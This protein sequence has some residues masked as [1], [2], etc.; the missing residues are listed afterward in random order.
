MVEREGGLKHVDAAV[1]LNGSGVGEEAGRVNGTEGR[2]IG[3]IDSETLR[4]LKLVRS[5]D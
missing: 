1:A 5:Y 3:A 4:I 2:D